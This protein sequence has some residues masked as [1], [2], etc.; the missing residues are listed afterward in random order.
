MGT[1]LSNLGKIQKEFGVAVL[2]IHH[3]GVATKDRARGSSAI[4]AALDTEIKIEKNDGTMSFKNTKQK[5]FEHFSPMSFQL[6]QIKLQ[7][8]Q[9]REL[10]DKYGDSITSCVLEQIGDERPEEDKSEP[11]GKNQRVFIRC[12]EELLKESPE[13]DRVKTA[14]LKEMVRTE[15]D[16]KDFSPVW[17]DLK[18]LDPKFFSIGD[19][20]TI[21]V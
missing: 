15:L 11:K 10:V 7:D 18:R 17:R 2:L 19:D 12:F 4:R 6:K 9:G 16:I 3:E 13:E 1:F 21:K 20:V 8:A 5:D 14:V